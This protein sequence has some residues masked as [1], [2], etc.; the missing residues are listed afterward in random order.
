MSEAK[1]EL[2]SAMVGRRN[3]VARITELEAALRKVVRS[4][5][6]VMP[7]ELDEEITEL[8]KPTGAGGE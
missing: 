8:L 3:L 7:I 6:V 2:P 1:H 5:D 4:Q